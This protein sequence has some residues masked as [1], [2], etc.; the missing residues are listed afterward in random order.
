MNS[1]IIPVQIIIPIVVLAGLAIAGFFGIN[2]A[3]ENYTQ[4]SFIAIGSCVLAWSIV[5]RKIW[6]LPIFF[7]SFLGGHFFFGFKIYATEL[8]V[9]VC[10]LPLILALAMKREHFKNRNFGIPRPVGILFLYLCLNFLACAVHNKVEELGGLGGV[11]RVY[12][13]ALWPFLIFL[14]FLLVGN[15]KYIPWALHLMA[16][17]IL[18]R[19]SIGM[20]TALF[21]DEDTILFIPGV[22]FI[23]AGGFGT[24]D[25]RFSGSMLCTLA[26][27]YFCVYRIFIVRCV[28]LAL[29]LVGVYGTFLGGGRVPIVLLLGIFV[30]A[31]LV[32][33]RY[34]LILLSTILLLCATVALNSFPEVLQEFPK[35]IKKACTVFLIDRNLATDTSEAASSDEWHYRLMKEGY[36]AWTEN[37]LT[38]LF[39]KG[40]RPFDIRAWGGGKDF[41]GMIEMAVATNR[42][43]SGLWT[44]LCT[45]GLVGFVLY[46]ILLLMII[47]YCVPVLQR[48][49]IKTPVHAIMFIA[50]YGCLSWFLLCWIAGGFPSTEILFGVIAMVAGHDMMGL[51]VGGKVESGKR[52]VEALES[53]DLNAEK[54]RA[55]T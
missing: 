9:L 23:P 6:W 32:Y 1:Q 42:Y 24:N 31:F 20:Y 5:G 12:L 26:V 52:K 33:R 7:F 21:C 17:A 51:R 34:G 10:L 36:K 40:T 3:N 28:M 18:I 29:I 2:I 27:C 22:N 39:G 11:T 41:E 47:G 44:I 53:E 14:P 13:A 4:L 54:L 37:G 46:S 55:E 16:S 15:T 35:T 30:F 48:E 25:L 50:V 19:F 49:K 43:E 8:A 38:I 45:F